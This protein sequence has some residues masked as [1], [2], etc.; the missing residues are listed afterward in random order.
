MT[1]AKTKPKLAMGRPSTA[2]KSADAYAATTRAAAKLEDGEA[3]L[4]VGM[5]LRAHQ[6]I[7]MRAV[8]R[9]ITI[10]QYVLELLKRDGIPVP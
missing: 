6:A 3:R 4:V 1:A 8:E 9:N 2:A 5:S 7:R 10:R